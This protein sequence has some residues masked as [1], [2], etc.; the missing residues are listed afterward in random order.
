MDLGRFFENQK[1]NELNKRRRIRAVDHMAARCNLDAGRCTN[2]EC[3]HWPRGNTKSRV[4]W[5]R[6]K[7]KLRYCD[8]ILHHNPRMVKRHL[9]LPEGL[10]SILIVSWP[11]TKC[12][13]IYAVFISSPRN[14]T[15]WIG[16]YFI[17]SRPAILQS[18]YGDQKRIWQ[19]SY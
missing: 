4:F 11:P 6:L 3:G 16:F 9:V 1:C 7:S 15:R 10:G 2:C 14:E 13:G 17:R 18:S 19:L 8:W 5:T 12:A